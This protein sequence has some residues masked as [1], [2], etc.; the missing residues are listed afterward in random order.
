MSRIKAL[1]LVVLSLGGITAFTPSRPAAATQPTASAMCA[2]YY[3]FYN[4]Q[5]N[6]NPS[7]WSRGCKNC[8]L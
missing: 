7:C 5:C 6:Y 2:R 3:C 1:A 8:I 4:G